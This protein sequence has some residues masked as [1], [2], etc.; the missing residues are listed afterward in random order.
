ML[1]RFGR[2]VHVTSEVTITSGG[3][4]V[5]FEVAK[6]GRL[7]QCS[8][9]RPVLEYYFQLPERA[10]DARPLRAFHDSHRR[11]LAIAERKALRSPSDLIELKASD[12]ER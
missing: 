11:I 4:A 7:V 3:G 10:S 1:F 6:R 2:T 9:G 8:I 12:F 5:L